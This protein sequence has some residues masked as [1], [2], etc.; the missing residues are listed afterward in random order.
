MLVHIGYH[1]T[2]TTWL[3]SVYFPRR[4]DLQVVGGY[5][6]LSRWIVDPD[7]L[8]FDAV[9][10]RRFFEPRIVAAADASRVPVLSTERLSG[11]PHSGGYDSKV[12]ADRLQAVFPEA[13]ILIVVRRQLD[14]A[15]S[16]YKQ[17]VRM[18]GICT[19]REYLF[20][21]RDGRIPLFRVAFLEYGRLAG[22]YARLFGAGRVRVMLYERLRDEPASFLDELAEFA[23][24]RSGV[25]FPAEDRV[26]ESMSDMAVLLKRR[27]NRWHGG[28]SLFP[29]T[30]PVPRVTG[31]LFR[32][33]TK[34]DRTGLARRFP[35]NLKS[36]AAELVAGRFRDSNR[37]LAAQFGLDLGK[38]GYEI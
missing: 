1:K 32:A 23:G 16:M 5:E 27:V 6:E 15:V 18:G 8:V 36:E 25:E 29:V 4:P 38:Y 19:L 7:G 14:M 37:E 21:P 20:P 34:F 31:A 13:R 26:N 17:Y 28:D 3:Q 33:V 10:A 11:N 12:I 9:A 30:P 22:Y 24:I 2:G 35:V